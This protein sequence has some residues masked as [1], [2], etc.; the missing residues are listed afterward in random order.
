V[1]RKTQRQCSDIIQ[2]SWKTS[3]LLT[4]NLFNTMHSKFYENWLVFM[5]DMTKTFWCVFSG[6][7]CSNDMTI[8]TKS[9]RL[10]VFPVHRTTVGSRPGSPRH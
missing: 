2:V 7:Q 6:S 1:N 3:K 9:D 8:L 10:R 4:A 5:E